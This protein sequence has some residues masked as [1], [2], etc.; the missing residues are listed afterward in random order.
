[1]TDLQSLWEKTIDFAV[2]DDGVPTPVTII[3]HIRAALIEQGSVTRSRITRGLKEAYRPF[4]V[5]VAKLRDSVESA[6]QEL[7]LIGDI[8]EFFTAAGRIYTIT[9]PRRVSWGGP[10]DTI[11]GGV[12]FDP[13]NGLVR[14]V[15]NDGSTAVPAGDV[16]LTE[17]LGRAA[18]R[19]SLVKIG[20]IDEVEAGPRALFETAA[21][22]AAGGERFDIERES[23][24]AVLSGEGDYF[25][26]FDP[27]PTGR[28]KRVKDEGIFAAAVKV[29]FE[30]RHVVLH[31]KNGAIH[32][33]QPPSRDIWN[34][35]VVGATLA[36]S[37]DVIKYDDRTELLTFLVP[38]PQQLARAVRLTGTQKAAWTWLIDPAAHSTI[39]SF[40]I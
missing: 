1:M 3:Q 30:I 20:G 24:V 10:S 33:W 32:L 13:G 2:T 28:W 40:L 29:G 23:S 4:G 22:L 12:A 26:R 9:Q 6:L 15:V 35:L 37:C 11:L 5:D 8:D 34:W 7:L 31:V 19:T 17:E 36:R 21:A 14:R 39:R 38:P 16:S 18:W 25:G 27:E